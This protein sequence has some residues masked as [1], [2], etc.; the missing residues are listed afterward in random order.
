MK[1]CDTDIIPPK[2]KSKVDLVIHT[3]IILVAIDVNSSTILIQYY[4]N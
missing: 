4:S 1:H 3:Y 2:Y